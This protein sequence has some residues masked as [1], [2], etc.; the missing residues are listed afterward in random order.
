LHEV[1]EWKMLPDRAN[2]L[3]YLQRAKAHAGTDATLNA[4][5]D[6]ALATLSK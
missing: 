3:S 5:I 2:A 1:R 6:T 4:D